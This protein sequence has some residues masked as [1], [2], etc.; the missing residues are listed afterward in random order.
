MEG[1][2]ISVIVPVY[3][4]EKYIERCLNSI[5]NQ[6]YRNLEIILIDDGSPDNC[7]QICDK[8]AVKDSR[9]KVIHQNNTGLSGA[10]NAA[11]RIASGYY[12]T[13]VDSDDWIELDMYEFLLNL[14]VQNDADIAHCSFFKSDG[15]TNHE[16]LGI[17]QEF[18]GNNFDS[19]KECLSLEKF[20]LSVWNKLYKKTILDGVF[21]EDGRYFEDTLFNFH[22]FRNSKLTVYN[23]IPKYYYFSRM[24]S[25]VKSKFSSK[26]LDVIYSTDKL[27]KLTKQYYP[28][29]LEYAERRDIVENI[30]II[31]DILTVD[32]PIVYLEEYRAIIT[33]LKRYS[34]TVK[35]NTKI[36]V[37]YKLLLTLLNINEHAFIY[38]LLKYLAK[39]K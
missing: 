14:A 30:L 37:K 5:V 20:I 25:I 8:W 7:P 32:E 19:M 13:F 39:K 9:I 26:N 27:C 31:N 2:L 6:T 21:F 28:D 34:K 22:A 33:K 11:L 18:L 38:L 24:D 15:L 3:K 12:I 29:L 36:S 17:G 4:V 1:P 23:G 16:G 35:G 10:R